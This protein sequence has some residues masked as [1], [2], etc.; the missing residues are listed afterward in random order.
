MAPH[1][2]TR[3]ENPRD[4]GAWWA[5][6]CGVAQSRTRLKRLS[7]SRSR[8]FYPWNSLGKNTGMGCHF[9]LQGI[10]LTQG[11]NPGLPHCRQILYHLNHLGSPPALQGRFLTT[12][13]PGKSPFP[14]FF[15]TPSSPCSRSQEDYPVW[16]STAG[17]SG[18]PS[19]RGLREESELGVHLAVLWIQDHCFCMAFHVTLSFQVW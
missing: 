5:A 1:S 9:L 11:L 19:R 6:V 10:F 16:V 7:S 13:L 18:S 12:G 17:F 15:L 14:I 2:S 8:L 4:G 3:L